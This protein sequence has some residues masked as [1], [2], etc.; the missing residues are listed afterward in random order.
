M[1]HD[2]ISLITALIGGGGNRLCNNKLSCLNK[3]YRPAR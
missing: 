1:T 3:T 2:N